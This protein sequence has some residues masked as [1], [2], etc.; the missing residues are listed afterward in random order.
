M[1][2]VAADVDGIEIHIFSINKHLL[3]INTDH[4]WIISKTK[5]LSL[6]V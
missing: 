2:A 4:I 6:K 5:E 3:L 1:T